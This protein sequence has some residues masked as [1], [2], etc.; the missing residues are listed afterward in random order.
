MKSYDVAFVN[1][2]CNDSFVVITPPDTLPALE[3]TVLNGAKS[4]NF[5]DFTVDAKFTG[6]A[7]CG[8]LSYMVKYENVLTSSDS[9]PM[10][11]TNTDTNEITINSDVTTLIG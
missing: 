10:A 2:C 9:E 7:I 4:Y 3:Y 1:P 11:Y 5:P 8:E 6:D